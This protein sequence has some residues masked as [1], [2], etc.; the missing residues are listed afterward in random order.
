MIVFGITTSFCGLVLYIVYKDCDPVLSGK[1][2]SYDRI[3]PY[4]AATKMSIYPGL[5]GLFIAGIFSASLSTISAL[6]NSLAAVIIE[7]YL[8]RIYSCMGKSFP[9]EK[10]ALVGKILVIV[11]GCGCVSIA[12]LAGSLGSLVQLTLSITGAICGPVLGIFTLGLF[13]ERA[14]EKGAVTGLLASL[15]IC[16][17]AAFGQ[18]RP[19]ALPPLPFSTDGC[20]NTILPSSLTTSPLSMYG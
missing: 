20:N 15:I 5:T 3:M 7:D 18:P 14:N 9:Q 1:I 6:L 2:T 16:L 8:K 11:N 12:F 13:F 10:T 4:F 17:W 19:K